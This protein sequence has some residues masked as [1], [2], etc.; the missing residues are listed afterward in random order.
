MGG[1]ARTHNGGVIGLGKSWNDG[2]MGRLETPWNRRE[3]ER[4]LRLELAPVEAVTR[5]EALDLSRWIGTSTQAHGFRADDR[6]DLVALVAGSEILRLSLSTNARAA[7]LSATHTTTGEPRSLERLL[8]A[9]E[10]ELAAPLTRRQLGRPQVSAHELDVAADPDALFGLAC[11]VAE[12]AWIDD[13]HFDLICSESGRNE[14]DN[15]FAEPFTAVALFRKPKIDNVWYTTRYDLDT[16]RFEAVHFVGDFVVG[17]M[18]FDVE[19]KGRGSRLR[20]ELEYEGVTPEGERLVAGRGLR[21]R[22]LRMQKFLGASAK[23]YI[24]RG[25]IL[26]LPHRRKAQI[27]LHLLG[28]EIGRRFFWRS[29]TL[30]A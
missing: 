1:P 16:R 27:A 17:R 22:M 11:P 25:E 20:F 23:H 6:C 21:E 4:P 12:L 18:A 13:W 15:V 14:P 9:A 3:L 5:F 10:A 30:F 2:D 26:R 8:D 29:A 7:S 24:E 28:A 19:P